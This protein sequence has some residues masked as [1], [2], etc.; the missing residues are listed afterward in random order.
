MANETPP[1]KA[2]NNFIENLINFTKSIDSTRLISAALE[3]HNSNGVNI[4]DDEIGK[5]LD[6]VAFNQYTGW[7]GGSLEDAPN[8][9]WNIKFNKPVV[10]SE[11]GGGALQGLHGT[12]KERWT[13]EYQEYLYQQ[14]IKTIER[15]PNIRGMSPWILADFRSPK[16]VLPGIQDGWNRKGLISNGG[17]KEKAFFTLKDFYKKIKK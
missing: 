7:Y 16:R 14:N 4:V 5:Y 12:T 3:K 1:S 15:I 2:R 6:I 17:V 13:E 10:I 8:A 9:K 11:F